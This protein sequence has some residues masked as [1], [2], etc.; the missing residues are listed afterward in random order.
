VATEIDWAPFAQ[1]IEERRRASGLTQRAAAD[2]AS[3]SGSQFNRIIKLADRER[4]TA[5]IEKPA[6][7]DVVNLGAQFGLTPNEIAEM[8]G[9]RAEAAETD[10]VSQDPQVKQLLFALGNMPQN[11]R[12]PFLDFVLNAASGGR[13]AR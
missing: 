3:M 1:V 11:V 6:F 7:V 4:E 2:R 13:V 10:G 9:L 5:T 8:I 12:M